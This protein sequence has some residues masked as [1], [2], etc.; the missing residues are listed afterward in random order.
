VWYIGYRSCHLGIIWVH[1]YD[2]TDR[3]SRERCQWRRR[4][5]YAAVRNERLLIVCWYNWSMSEWLMPTIAHVWRV[6]V[7]SR[8]C[9]CCCCC[10]TR[11]LT[12]WW[13]RSCHR[14]RVPPNCTPDSH[15]VNSSTSRACCRARWTGIALS[16]LSITTAL[17]QTDRPVG[18]HFLELVHCVAL[19]RLMLLLLSALALFS[20]FFTTRRYASAVYAVVVCPSVCLS[21]CRK[22]VLY[23]NGWTQDN[24][25]NAIR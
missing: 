10:T 1:I 9:C 13:V 11:W 16:D 20:Q 18:S 25:N 17:T 8:W 5:C 19:L 22:P 14:L 15:G 21:V 6:V 23:Q 12:C 2:R 7:G 3:V 24:E 4:V